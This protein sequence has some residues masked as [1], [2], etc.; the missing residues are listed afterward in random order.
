MARVTLDQM[1]HMMNVPATAV[2][3][4]ERIAHAWDHRQPGLDGPVGRYLVAAV[5]LHRRQL[6]SQLAAVR[7]VLVDGDE[8]YPDDNARISAALDMIGEVAP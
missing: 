3:A 6:V 7:D 4:D 8:L 1:L 2:T 5:L